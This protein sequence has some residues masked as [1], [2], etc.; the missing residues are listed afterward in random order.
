[1]HQTAIRTDV[2]FFEIYSIR[3]PW[4]KLGRKMGD[5]YIPELIHTV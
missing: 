3:A 5:T 4:V 2:N 1:M